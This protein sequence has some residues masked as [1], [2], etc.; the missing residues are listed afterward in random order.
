[1][2]SE[3]VIRIQQLSKAYRIYNRP[4]DRVL[5]SI[6]HRSRIRKSGTKFREIQALNPDRKSVV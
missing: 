1:M 5:E 2:S 4:I 3:P 6:L